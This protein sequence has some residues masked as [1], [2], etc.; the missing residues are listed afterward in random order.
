MLCVM[1]F[2]WHLRMDDT[3]QIRKGSKGFAAHTPS[4]GRRRFPPKRGAY[5]SDTSRRRRRLGQRQKQSL[6]GSVTQLFSVSRI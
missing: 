5:V 1:L 6:G 3:D 4:G 2:F